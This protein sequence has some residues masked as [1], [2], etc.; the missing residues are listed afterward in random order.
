MSTPRKCVY[1]LIGKLLD[2]GERTQKARELELTLPSQGHP[3]SQQVNAEGERF[4]RARPCRHDA[5]P[6]MNLTFQRPGRHRCFCREKLLVDGSD[7]A[8]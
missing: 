8:E 2:V 5:A 3:P 4:Q 1:C 7:V 6:G